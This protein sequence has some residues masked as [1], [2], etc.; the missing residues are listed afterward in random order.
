MHVR[1]THFT[2][3]PLL[4][5]LSQS[6]RTWLLLSLT[7]SLTSPANIPAKPYLPL[8]PVIRPSYLIIFIAA[9]ACQDPKSL[10]ASPSLKEAIFS[11]WM[12]SPW[13]IR[14]GAD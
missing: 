6:Q 4:T 1:E 5:Y 8:P 11:L 3:F 13:G 12:S 10:A 2:L 9:P 7:P 14:P